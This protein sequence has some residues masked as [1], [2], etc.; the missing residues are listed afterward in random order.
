MVSRDYSNN[1]FFIA[2]RKKDVDLIR[3]AE[4]AKSGPMYP[5]STKYH[6]FMIFDIGLLLIYLIKSGFTHLI[7]QR[8]MGQLAQSFPWAK[9]KLEQNAIEKSASISVSAASAH[10]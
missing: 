3:Q 4:N 1:F 8:P 2:V 10:Q 5:N 7:T 9:M 6:P